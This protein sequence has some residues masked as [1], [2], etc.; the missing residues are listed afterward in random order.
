MNILFVM[1][2]QHRGDCIGAA[3]ASW[4]KTPALDKL[5]SEGVL[6]ENAY[7]SV[8]SCLPARVSLLT[9]MSPW[10]SGQLGYTPIPEYQF[11]LP[12]IFTNAG[13]RTHAVGK[14]H[15]IFSSKVSDIV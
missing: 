9:G 8:P 10:Q 15:F 1:G 13:Y 14:N 3:G 5:A 2:D 4:L 6:F 12:R 11:E 7:A